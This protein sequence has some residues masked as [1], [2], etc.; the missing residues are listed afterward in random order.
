MTEMTQYVLKWFPPDR[1]VQEMTWA[2]GLTDAL[3]QA[4][5]EAARPH[6]RPY[7]PVIVLRTTIDDVVWAPSSR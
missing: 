7:A 2:S 3:A 5:E 1:Q 4:Q 6:V